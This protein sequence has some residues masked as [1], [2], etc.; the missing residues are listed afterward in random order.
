[1]HRDRIGCGMRGFRQ[2][3]RTAPADGAH[4][5]RGETQPLEA[6]RQ[7][8]GAGGLAVGARDAGNPQL[9]GGPIEEPVGDAAH[10]IL[11]MGYRGAEHSGRQHRRRQVGAAVPTAPRSRRARAASAANL[12]P[13]SLQSGQCEEQAARRAPRGCR[14]SDPRRALRSPGIFA[15]PSSSHMSAALMAYRSPAPAS[16]PAR[17]AN[18][19]A[20]CPSSAAC[21]T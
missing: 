21:R 6:L 9:R 20:E 16:P 7:Q 3:C 4:V 17:S 1:M 14:A 18:H 5:G 13:C 12:R 10:Q 2:R 19:R 15:M 8:V 11:Q